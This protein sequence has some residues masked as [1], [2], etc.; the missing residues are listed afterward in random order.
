MRPGRSLLLAPL[1][2]LALLGA[3]APAGAATASDEMR[4]C[5]ALGPK[6][7][8]NPADVAMGD[9]IA[10]RFRA[11]GLE[12]SLE[13]FHMPVWQFG[14]STMRIA[15]G[16][17]AGTAFR[18][19]SFAYS[20]VG[21]VRGGVVDAGSGG[22][23][24]YAGKDVKGKVVIVSR[25]E[26]FH[27][28]VQVE[29]A[30]AR[31]A[32]AMVLVSGSPDNLIQTGAVRW[33]QRPP[34]PIPA[35]TIGADDGARLRDR[36]G[37]GG[38]TVAIA[39]RGERVDRV[40]RNVVG[41]RRGTTYPDRY[42]VVAGHYDSWYAGAFDNCTAVGS[43]LRLAEQSRTFAPKYTTIYIGWDA[44]EPG[45]VGS[46]AWLHRHPELIPKIAVNINLEETASATF[47][48]GDATALPSLSLT[49]GTGAPALTA[50][51]A[52]SAA[53]TLFTPVI[54]PIGIYRG[55]SG[56]IIATDLEGFY[57][58]GV[59]GVSTAALSGYYHTTEDTADK[60][61]TTDLERVTTFL[62]ALVRNVQD[63]PPP[64]LLVREVPTLE[65]SAPQKAA[66]GA[67]VPID[68][69]LTG[70]DGRPIGGASPLMLADQNDNWAVAEGRAKDLGGGR[71]RWT[72]PAGT[73]DA[74]LTRLRAT[75]NAPDYLAVAQ[76]TIDQRDSGLL[77]PAAVCR[78]RRV[79]RLHVPRRLSGGRRVVSLRHR[80]S[81]GKLRIV[82]RGPRR[83]TLRLDLRGVRKGAVTVR[84]TART[85]RGGTIRQTRTYRPCT[86]GRG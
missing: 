76:G 33:A 17:G 60:V 83:Y 74:D 4:A 23:S 78:S 52:V 1:V 2:L 55:L 48:D 58:A 44:E 81:A 39:A 7:P 85:S 42:V 45:L 9:R 31:G 70:T 43:L 56:G 28:T 50:S 5:A 79:I 73:T 24:D 13:S 38:V 49:S 65:L 72:L 47:V 61:N 25:S 54:A 63:V 41:I 53:T 64:A 22:P 59:Q 34:A 26:T 77:P 86:A 84:L 75:V 40:G 19:E 69:R 36:V 8:G 14:T 29:E 82:G 37:E 18:V 16:P 67:A 71:Y 15:A 20:G 6:R 68:L 57:G 51:L 10:S 62:D 30:A 21:D 32:V 27:R 66:P 35:I 80:T 3:Q 12:T 11:A 46:Y